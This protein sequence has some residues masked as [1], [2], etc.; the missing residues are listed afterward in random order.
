MKPKKLLGFILIILG[1]A[2]VFYN[3][4]IGGILIFLGV[5]LAIVPPRKLTKRNVVSEYK[6]KMSALKI[7]K[8][9][10]ALKKREEQ[11]K[12]ARE[13]QLRAAKK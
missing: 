11:L 10:K 1:I 6:H 8:R 9:E 4:W 13:T 12:K 3:P 7:E 2:S 5:L